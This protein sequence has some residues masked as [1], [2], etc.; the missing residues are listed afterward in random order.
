MATL[1]TAAALLAAAAPAPGGDPSPVEPPAETQ[2][3]AASQPTVEPPAAQLAWLEEVGPLLGDEEREVFLALGRDYQREAFIERFWELRDPFPGTGRNEFRET[4]E[5]RL[6]LARSRY[7]RLDGD[8]A[9]TLLLAGPPRRT[10]TDPCPGE[11]RPVEI[12]LY[13]RVEGLAGG[14]ALFFVRGAGGSP[15]GWSHWSPL[16]GLPLSFGRPGSP[17]P[18][19]PAAMA[20]LAT[21]CPR[22]RDVVDAFAQAV[23][24]RMLNTRVDL[25]P[26]PSGEWARAFLARTT[27]LPE[28]AELLPASV[29]L[30]FPGRHQ[31]RTVVQGLITVPR[32]AAATGALGERPTHSFIVD[33]EVLREGRLFE[34]F[35]YRFDLP[36]DEAA[37]ELPLAVQR[38]LRPGEYDLIFRVRDVNSQHGFR[39]EFP[40]HV[41]AVP[42]AAEATAVAEAPPP[43][44]ASGAVAAPAANREGAA[45]PRLAEANATGGDWLLAIQPLPEEL[46]T[47]RV[48][49]EARAEG[50]GIERVAFLLDGQPVMAKTRPPYSVELDLGQAPRLRTL[51][52]VAFGAGGRELARDRVPVN[53]GPHRFGVRLLEP[54]PGSRHSTSLRARAEVDLP[55]GQKLDRLEFFLN[56]TRL[57]SLYQP[58]FVQPILLPPSRDITY[59]RAVAYLADGNATEDLVFIN[60]PPGMDRLRINFV[61]LFTSVLDS[62]G[63]PVQGLERE[64]FTVL[65]E[66]REQTIARFELV[67]DLPIHAGVLLDASTSMLEELP[68]AIRGALRFFEGVIK[69]KDRAAVV[70]F[71]D[72]PRLT[73]PFTNR[74]DVLAGG[75]SGLEAEGETALYDSLVFTFHY[76]AG[77]RGKRVVILLSDGEDSHSRHSFDEALDFAKRTGVAVYAIGINLP[78]RDTLVRSRLARLAR[79]TGG[80]PFFIQRAVELKKIY[81]SIETELRSQYLLAYQ[82]THESG[83]DFRE[84]EVRVARQGLEAKTVPGYYP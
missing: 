26:R 9:K 23:D 35:R 46:L 8:R 18:S 34:R 53:A 11:L 42:R 7:R 41:P 62:K 24:W 33:G 71:N 77:L 29:T 81:E 83:G 22:G 44:A 45:G 67:R 12:W 3:E 52:A 25:V 84:V 75:L 47:G 73:V 16:R 1:L 19:E 20:R 58:P 4:W 66:G 78:R 15:D 17:L 54:Q 65:E 28:G 70:V 79:E 30:A 27:D 6:E 61:E 82:S 68:E 5:A 14:F 37:G 39:I 55:R 50:D 38:F 51:E 56:E 57:A 60:A 36:A 2:L 31:S 48:R 72:A 40:V 59:V 74:H 10:F 43:A 80:R 49:V 63:Q 21:D 64:E 32:E 69:P 13:D 76:F